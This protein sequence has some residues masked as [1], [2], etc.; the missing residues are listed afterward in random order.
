MNIFK[1]YTVRVFVSMRVLCYY[2]LYVCIYCFF[3]YDFSTV[4]L[5]TSGILI[6]ALH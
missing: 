1:L 6:L 3:H 2:V 5:R 4:I